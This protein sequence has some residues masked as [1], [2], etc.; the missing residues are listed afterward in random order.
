MWTDSAD[1]LIVA[2]TILIFGL[3]LLQTLRTGHVHVVVGLP[4]LPIGRAATPILY[5]SAV[6]VLA[7]V[8]TLLAVALARSVGRM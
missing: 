8:C 3:T 5:W 1:V 4:G 2:A 6:C 7:G